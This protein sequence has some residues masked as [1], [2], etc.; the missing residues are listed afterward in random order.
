MGLV[1]TWKGAAQARGTHSLEMTEG[2][3]CQDMER[4]RSIEGH[5][6]PGDGRGRDLSAHGKNLI[7]PGALTPWRHQRERLVM[8]RKESDRVR[9]THDLEKT[10]KSPD[11]DT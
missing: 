7:K 9:G 1:R 6:L 3:T 11:Q 4:N 10:K 8:T 2:G 5:S